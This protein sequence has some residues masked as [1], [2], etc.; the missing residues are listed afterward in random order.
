MLFLLPTKTISSIKCIE[1][2]IGYD[3]THLNVHVSII[4]LRNL[5]SLS[6]NPI[7]SLKVHANSP[8]YKNRENALLCKNQNIM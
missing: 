5:L 7:D 6:A 8:A 4:I 2:N 1:G 3:K